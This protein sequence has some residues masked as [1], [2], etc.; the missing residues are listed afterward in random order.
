[1]EVVKK[2][3]EETTELVRF[4]L[5]VAEAV[6]K[7]LADGSFDF[8]DVVE[9]LDALRLANGAFNDIAKVPGELKDLDET[10]RAFL[11][12]IIEEFDADQDKA[13]EILETALRVGLDIAALI[14]KMW[15]PE[16]DPQ[17]A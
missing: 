16:K 10:E 4:V 3:V 2:G 7:S 17:A 1:M 5:A 9:F 11:F 14:S 12:D 15:P 13:E 8:M 6:D